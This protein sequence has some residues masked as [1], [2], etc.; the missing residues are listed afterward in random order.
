[1]KTFDNSFEPEVGKF[2]LVKCAK[3]LEQY[4]GKIH[5]TPIIGEKHSDD[6]FGVFWDHYHIDG[7]FTD[8]KT[9]ERFDIVNGHTNVIIATDRKD[10]PHI[11]QG[12][13]LKKKK[14][15]RLITGIEPPEYARA[16]KYWD[17]RKSMSGKKVRNGICPH[18]GVKM[19]D[20]GDVFVCPLHGLVACKNKME[21][22]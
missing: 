16:K 14:C 7:R 2:Y 13:E 1:M 3:M 9:N 12:I 5:Y 17:W 6:A 8:N 20:K 19:H 10:Y 18:R 4:S 15:Q 11:F 21:I 22:K